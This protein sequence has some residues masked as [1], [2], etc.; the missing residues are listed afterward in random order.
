[1]RR[2]LWVGDGPSQGQA[3]PAVA[4][5][6]PGRPEA[7]AG[8]AAAPHPRPQ[9]CPT[10]PARV[11]C[12]WRGPRLRFLPPP[13]SGKPTGWVRPEPL[14]PSPP[15]GCGGALQRPPLVGGRVRPLLMLQRAGRG[16]HIRAPQLPPEGGRTRP[17]E[18]PLPK[19]GCGASPQ[20]P[21][22]GGASLSARNSTGGP[23]PRSPAPFL[24]A[25]LFREGCVS[26][27]LPLPGPECRPSVRGA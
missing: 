12:P 17:R 14:R 25:A 24:Q 21:I 6:P 16:V 22:R 26:N 23:H 9:L 2:A 18:F 3:G 7:A 27:L 4:H 8:A 11:Y 10:S 15:P 5:F 20:S 19:S 1:M 13:L